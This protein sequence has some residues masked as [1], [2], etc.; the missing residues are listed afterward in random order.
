MAK[1][2]A[3]GKAFINAMDAYAKHKKRGGKE[4]NAVQSAG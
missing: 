1:T 2:D 3:E 4:R